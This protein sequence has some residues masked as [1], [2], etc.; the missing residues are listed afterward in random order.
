MYCAID[1]TRQRS[2]GRNFTLIDSLHN[3][4]ASNSRLAHVAANVPGAMEL[5]IN[6][7]G[8]LVWNLVKRHVSCHSTAED[9]VQEVFTEIWKSASR[10]D[11]SKGN[12]VTFIATIARRRAIDS[13]RRQNTKLSTVE[14]PYDF[15]QLMISHTPDDD[16]LG[17]LEQVASLVQA[18]PE[19]TQRLFEL[20]YKSGL[21]QEEIAQQLDMP[22]GTVKTLLRRGLLDIRSR[23]SRFPSHSSI[24][25]VT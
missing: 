24:A 7:Y 12:E 10:F 11:A 16:S 23:L 3:N 14:L 5:C 9:I 20:H 4:A 2:Y 22:L 21:T 15:D 25:S 19:Q 13:I 17:D 6:E 1:N 8:S 18:L